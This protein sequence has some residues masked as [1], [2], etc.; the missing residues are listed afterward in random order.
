MFGFHP[1]PGTDVTERVSTP[2]GGGNKKKSRPV[3]PSAVVGR[4]GDP[5]TDSA[6]RPQY[7]VLL[8]YGSVVGSSPDQMHLAHD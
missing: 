1:G 7:E 6:E 5:S 4:T 3:Q 8:L 2:F